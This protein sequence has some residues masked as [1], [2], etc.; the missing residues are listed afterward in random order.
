MTELLLLRV[1]EQDEAPT[2]WLLVDTSGVPSGGP[3]R[4]TLQLA[5]PIAA[6]RRVVALVPGV[7]VL[8]AQPELP[9]KSGSR[10]AQVVPFALEEHIAG[11]VETMHF[12]VGRR[13]G[14]H[15][16]TPVAALSREKFA[17]WLQR[18]RSAGIEPHAVHVDT[19]LVPSIPGQS[20]LLVDGDQLHVRHPERQPF[21]LNAQP[22]SE[23]LE[24]TGIL[25][26]AEPRNVI[27]YLTQE[28][29]QRHQPAF[30]AIRDRLAGL[31]VQ[32]LPQGVLPLFAQEIVARA[33]IDLM[34]GP[35]ARRTRSGES[36]RR[37]R[38]AAFLLAGLVGLN[39]ASKAVEFWRLKSHERTLDAAI[40]QVFGEAMPG[41][42]N[43]IDARRRMEAR[44]AAIRGAGSGD[45][46]LLEVLAILR[47]A[48]AQVPQARVDALSFRSNVLDLKIDAQDVASL[49]RLEQ[50]V[51]Q[52]GLDA[53]L[54]S[55][56]ARGQTIE[57]RMQIRRRNGSP[58]RAAALRP[59]S[60]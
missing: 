33:P 23:A 38:V 46:N 55:S 43:A 16:G 30:E 39:L 24:L 20:V 8:L 47:G 19:A 13:E 7:D 52:G 4:G 32:L 6:A 58:N 48:F 44:L 31:K 54:Q 34:Q 3:Q 40:E 1:P 22:M 15:P 41:Q 18:L 42:G 28:D 9:V 60:E 45:D 27:A 14:S 35:Y 37:W 53:E 51:E 56:N 36:W 21:V 5:A 17:A 12:A 2:S 49:D 26:G 57:G 25:D 29:W 59:G 10:L 50:L 11:D